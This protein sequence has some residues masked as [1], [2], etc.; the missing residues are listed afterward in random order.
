MYGGSYASGGFIRDAVAK[1][2]GNDPQAEARLAEHQAASPSWEQRAVGTGAFAGLN[3]PNYLLTEFAPLARASAPFL[4]AIRRLNLPEQGMT[5]EVS[6]LTTG[7]T[8]EAQTVEGAAVSE[9]NI[10]DTLLSIPVRTYAGS[11]DVSRQAVDRAGVD[12]LIFGDLAADYLRKVDAGAITGTGAN[13]QHLGLLNVAGIGSVAYTDASPTVGEVWPKIAQAASTVATNRFLPADTLLMHP[14]RWAWFCAAL[15]TTGRPLVSPEANGPHNAAGIAGPPSAEGFVGKVQGLN[16]IAD[17]GV[18]I[19][20][21]AGT[22]EDIIVVLRA[23]DIL[24]WT[25]ESDLMPRQL[26]VDEPAALA[27]LQIR[28]VAYGYSAFT[29]GRYPSAIAT[30]GGTG[31]V[32]PTFA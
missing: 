23:S 17:A 32:T 2:F 31:L 29:A 16:V 26:R 25:E 4:S 15:D 7:S 11:Q 9:T 22:N 8:V 24:L 10:D 21:G 13:G 5:I 30:V 1:R 12:Q 19:N 6:R 27:T 28:L 3:V 14:R 20:L 18:P